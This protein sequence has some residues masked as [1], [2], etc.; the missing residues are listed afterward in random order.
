[1]RTLALLILFNTLT[2][3][4]ILFAQESLCNQGISNEQDSVL[5]YKKVKEL[6]EL[7]SEST[8]NLLAKTGR[9]FIGYPYTHKTLETGNVESLVVNFRE[10]D[11]T[12]FVETCLAFSLTLKSENITFENFKHYLKEIRYR[13]GKIENYDSRLHYFTDWITDN[14]K[15]GF[16]TDTTK[17]LCGILR[18]K[19]I[20]F[21]S[22]HI[23][24]YEQLKNDSNLIPGIREIEKEI[25]N[26]LYDL[27]FETGEAEV[28]LLMADQF[29]GH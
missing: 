2:S 8:A 22:T 29:S 5:F 24:A 9:S 11:C 27:E 28:F 4:N 3:C 25:T 20:D 7:S 15:K 10:F 19:Q 16:I 21:M 23:D 17:Y 18:D 12:T 26:P 6:K 13:D 14:Q 1:M